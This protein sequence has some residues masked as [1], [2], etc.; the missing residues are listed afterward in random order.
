MSNLEINRKICGLLNLEQKTIGVLSGPNTSAVL[1][2]LGWKN[3]AG[4]IADAWELFEEMPIQSKI[5]K[6]AGENCWTCWVGENGSGFASRTAPLAICMAWIK[7]KE[8]K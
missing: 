2:E 8:S 5:V 1:T 6:T 3:W 7:W 4:N